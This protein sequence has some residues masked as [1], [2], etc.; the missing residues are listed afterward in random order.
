MTGARILVVDDDPGVC[1][2]L[3]DALRKK[4][5]DVVWR[6]SGPEALELVRTEHLDAVV[7]DLIMRGMGGLEVCS[8][9]AAEQPALPVVV[10]TAFG[11]LDTRAAAFDA[12]AREVIDKPFALDALREALERAIRRAPLTPSRGSEREVS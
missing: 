2:F 10:I 1:E 12:G 6:T 9:I 11:S 4:G 5:F 7:T 8:R 3:Q